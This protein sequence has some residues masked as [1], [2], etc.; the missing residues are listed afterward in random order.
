MALEIIRIASDLPVPVADVWAWHQR[1]GALGR[2]LPPWEPIELVSQDAG[3]GEGARTTVR[4][5]IGPVGVEWI[6]EH[7]APDPPYA[8]TDFQVEGPFARWQHRHLFSSLED[9]GCEVEDRI[10][11]ELPFEPCSGLAVGRLMRERVERGIAY[12]HRVLARDFERDR[13]TPLAPGRRIAITGMSGMIGT[14]LARVLSTGGHAPVAVVRAGSDPPA[15]AHGTLSWDIA[16]RTI[17]AA[18]LEGIDAVVHLAGEP[19]AGRWTPEK[20]RRILE[21]RVEGTGLLARTVAGLERPPRVLICASAI[22][23]YGD[24][25][26]TRLEEAANPGDGFLADVVRAWEAAADPAR[27]AGIRVIHLRVGLVLWP[28]GGALERLLLPMRAGIGGRLGSGRQWWSWVTLDDVVGATLHAIATDGLAGP[29]NVVAPGPV[30]NAEFTDVLARVLNR[31]AFLPAPAP[32]LRVVLGEEAADQLLLSSARVVPAALQRTGYQF[33]DPV[34][35]AA[36]RH[37]LGRY[38]SS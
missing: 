12:R 11:Y 28:G 3:V 7:L 2:L 35:E 18:A 38:P 34:L 27:A 29:V 14:E 30:R 22:G 31:P 9:G 37:Q 16:K 4:V 26:D 1:V 19:I 5:G 17:D 36:L 24:R 13:R 15:A 21:S 8:F 23:L 6:S 10:E 33:S 20:R 25:G 32:V